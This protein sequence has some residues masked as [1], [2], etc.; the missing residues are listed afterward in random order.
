MLSV[1]PPHEACSCKPYRARPWQLSGVVLRNQIGPDIDN[2]RA[3]VDVACCFILLLS[4]EPSLSPAAGVR[5][6]AVG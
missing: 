4:E 5:R 2:D 6:D 1:S 3:G